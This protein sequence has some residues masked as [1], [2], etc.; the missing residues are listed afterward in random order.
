MKKIIS[1]ILTVFISLTVFTS[2]SSKPDIKDPNEILSNI[3]ENYRKNGMTSWWEILAVYNAGEN[4]MD[5]KG[6]DEILKSLEGTTNS[7]MASY[8]TVANIAVVIGADAGYFEKYEEYKTNLKSLLE[9]PTDKY[10]LNDYIFGY[11]ALK[12]S[13]MKFD[14]SKVLNYLIQA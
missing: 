14:E 3:L 5:Y 11:L 2:C 1:V 6:F 4:P 9:N 12:C 13:G 8:V 7:K 10:T